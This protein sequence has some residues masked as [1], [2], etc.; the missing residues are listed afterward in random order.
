MGQSKLQKIIV[1]WGS[2]QLPW[3]FFP[4]GV[5]V[6]F[7][8]QRLT[9]ENAKTHSSGE[10]I[11]HLKIQYKLGEELR[12]LRVGTVATSVLPETRRLQPNEKYFAVGDSELKR[13]EQSYFRKVLNQKMKEEYG[14]S[15]GGFIRSQGT[16]LPFKKASVD[17]LHMHW[18]LTA[19]NH[20]G[21]EN[22]KKLSRFLKEAGRVLKPGGKIFITDTESLLPQNTLESLATQKGFSVSER[23]GLKESLTYSLSPIVEESFAYSRHYLTVLEK[24]PQ[25]Q[26]MK[27]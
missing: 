16:G 24:H 22:T 23:G 15:F 6:W 8:G 17:E 5:K 19:E 4:F 18:L 7:K 27:H 13:G 3:P 9:L 2:G 20:K 25:I 14:E 26:Q 21:E 12:E 1:D 10:K 11:A